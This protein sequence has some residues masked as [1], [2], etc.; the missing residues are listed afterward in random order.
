ME[1]ESLASLNQGLVHQLHE[2]LVVRQLR[3]MNTAHNAM[4][5]LWAVNVV[6]CLVFATTT[7][8][9][10]EAANAGW[11]GFTATSI[12]KI[13]FGS[14]SV[15]YHLWYCYFFKKTSTSRKLLSTLEA[16]NLALALGTSNFSSFIS[17]RCFSDLSKSIQCS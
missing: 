17:F 11:S 3:H 10:G 16:A 5:R 1:F 6:N 4:M 8:E 2:G 14:F 15:A 12:Y 13:Y 7:L 9:H